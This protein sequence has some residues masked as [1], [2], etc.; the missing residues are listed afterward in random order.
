MRRLDI[1]SSTTVLFLD[2]LEVDSVHNAELVVNQAE[3]CAA[4]PVLPLGDQDEWDLARASPWGG[5]ILFDGE[6]QVFKQW[7]LGG[8]GKDEDAHIG[9]AWS[10]DGIYW[11]KPRLHPY[12]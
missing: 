11:H 9:Y 6:E 8:T 1:T 2:M 12:L 5:T 3:K 4:N 7:Y 10:E